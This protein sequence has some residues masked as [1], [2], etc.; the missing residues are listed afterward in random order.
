[1]LQIDFGEVLI[2]FH[3]GG[4][5]IY[6]EASLLEDEVAEGAAAAAASEGSLR[7]SKKGCLRAA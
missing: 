3:L 5:Q 2:A 4:L 6:L 1:M 7:S